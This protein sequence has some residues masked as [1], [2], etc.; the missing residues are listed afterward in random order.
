MEACNNLWNFS[1]LKFSVFNFT[2]YLKNSK[3]LTFNDTSYESSKRH[4]RDFLQ[5]SFLAN[6]SY[7]IYVKN[8]KFHNTETLDFFS[9]SGNTLQIL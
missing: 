7:Y 3:N 2:V 8:K 6:S 1:L 5:I 4:I 9:I